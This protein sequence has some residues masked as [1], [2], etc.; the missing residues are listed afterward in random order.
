M[1]SN[2]PWRLVK[3]L[4]RKK[5]REKTNLTV[6]EGPSVVINALESGIKINAVIVTEEFA[7]T[8][9]GRKLHRAMTQHPS[10]G[11]YFVVSSELYNRMS[12]TKSPQ[13]ALCLLNFPFCFLSGEPQDTW[14]HSLDIVGVDVQDPGNVGTI[15][16]NGACV[17]ASNI[18]MCGQ[19][20][21][22]FSPKVIRASVGMI[23]KVRTMFQ[24]DSM[25]VLQNLHES[26]TMLYKTVPRKGIMPWEANFRSPSALVLGNEGQGLGPDVLELPGTC[27]TIPMPG[28]AESLNVAM[29]CSALLYETV[30]QRIMAGDI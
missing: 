21:D 28:A 4:S 19:S 23:F 25:S 2:V 1:Y 7:G 10:P 17:G 29:A 26:G 5:E 3:S 22:P 15:I 14:K 8:D 24:E 30:R 12:S 6:A 18:I 16:R 20:A 11:K 13:G 9:R 27:I